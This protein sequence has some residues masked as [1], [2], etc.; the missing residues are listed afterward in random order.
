MS[1]IVVAS[2]LLF[3]AQA[4]PLGEVAGH[5]PIILNLLAGSMIW[6]WC[7]AD[8]ATRMRASLLYRI[9]AVLL[10]LMA[11]ALLFGHGASVQGGPALSGLGLMVAGVAAG[12]G[13]GVVASFLG[14]A[15]ASFS[16]RP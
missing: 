5:W 14:V 12:F 4:I 15:G 3:R 10:V 6:A 2:A 11:G 8:W 1:L 9:M 16:S 7:A 13:I